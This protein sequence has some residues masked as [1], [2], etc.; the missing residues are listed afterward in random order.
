[1]YMMAKSGKLM[2]SMID[3]CRKAKYPLLLVYGLKD[4]IVDKRGCDL[5]VKEWKHE[6]KQ[7]LLIENGSHGKSTVKLARD[8]I[9]KWIK[10]R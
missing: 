9:N 8:T 7:Y 2:N 1:M 5:I 6:K 10:E 3:Y 4:S